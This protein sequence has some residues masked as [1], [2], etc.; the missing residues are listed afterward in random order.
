MIIYGINPVLEALRGGRVRRL[1]VGPR[2]TGASKRRWRSRRKAGVAVERVDAAA[3]DRAAR[4]GVHQGIVAE[5]EPPRDYAS[6]SWSRRPRRAARCSSCSTASRIR[7]TSARSCGPSTRPARTASCGRRGTR[8]RST[9]SRRRRRRARWP[10]AHRDR[11]EHRARGRGA[12]EAGVWTVGLAGE[13]PDATTRSTSR[14][15]RRSCSGPKGAGCGGWSAS[16]A[17]GWCRSRCAGRWEPEVSV[18]AGVMLFEAARQRR[19]TRSCIIIF[20][21]CQYPLPFMACARGTQCATNTL[22]VW[23]GVAQ[24]G[25]A[26]D[27]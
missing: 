5:L 3:L 8:R 14:C 21:P 12:E 18:A 10:R 20:S 26:A 25:R 22:F 11:S 2:S 19:L 1:R 4:G 15:R 23:A 6:R 17:T 7:T 27:L 9:A 13:A 16:A 24:S